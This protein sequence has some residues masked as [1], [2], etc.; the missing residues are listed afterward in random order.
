MVK[1]LL[2]YYSKSGRTSR[3]ARLISCAAECDT[4]RIEDATTS[5]HELDHDITEY[6][7]VILGMPVWDNGI[8]GPMGTVIDTADWRG[9]TIHPFFTCGGIFRDVFTVLKDKCKGAA[10]TA[11]LYLI[12]NSSGELTDIRE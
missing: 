11:P 9:I 2:V 12:F 5:I 3:I 10:F 6:G 4:A 1:N 8:P 7:S